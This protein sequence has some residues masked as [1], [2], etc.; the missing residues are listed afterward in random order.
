M[1]VLLSVKPKNFLDVGNMETA[2]ICLTARCLGGILQASV[3]TYMYAY[4]CVQLQY[5]Q[6]HCLHIHI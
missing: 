1:L 5:L 2:F 4:V 3:H 6:R